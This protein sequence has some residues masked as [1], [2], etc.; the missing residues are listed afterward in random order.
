MSDIPKIYQHLCSLI[1]HPA[2]GGGWNLQPGALLSPA[3]SSSGG[4][5]PPEVCMYHSHACLCTYSTCTCIHKQLISLS[6]VLKHLYNGYQIVCS[7]LQLFVPFSPALKCIQPDACKSRRIRRPCSVVVSS[8]IYTLEL[9]STLWL[10]GSVVVPSVLSLQWPGSSPTV[11]A[12]VCPGSLGNV[13]SWGYWPQ[14]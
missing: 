12:H 14:N 4:P 10:M 5:R 3:L 8:C 11:F 13:C 7:L 6:Y 1:H 2:A 9:F